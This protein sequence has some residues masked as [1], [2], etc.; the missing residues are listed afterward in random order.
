MKLFKTIT[1]KFEKPDWALNPE[2]GLIDTLLE[3]HPEL[4]LLVKDDIMVKEKTSNFGRGD[5]PTVEQIL[6]A[7]I[8][9]EMKGLDYRGLE[10]AQSDSRICATFLKLDMRKPF[11]FQL[12]QKYIARIKATSLQKLL[13]EINKIAIAE[14]YEDVSKLRQDTSTVEANIHYPTNNS[15]VWD[16]I[17]ESHRLLEHLQKE[18]DTLSYRDYTTTAKQTYFKIN[19]TKADKRTHLFKKQ[20]ITFTK[21]IN[22]V[23]NAIKKSPATTKRCSSN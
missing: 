11:S 18:M 6:R 9:K 8:Y 19:N 12:F 5:V 15:L 16:C 2:F 21:T 17:K 13:V 20:L 1:L 4:L 22:Q 10:Y 7:A 3:Q 14:G 23:S